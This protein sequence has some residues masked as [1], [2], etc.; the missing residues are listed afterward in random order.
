MSRTGFLYD[1]TF[2]EHNTGWKHPEKRQRLIALIEHLTRTGLLSR[3]VP[4]TPVS[5]TPDDIALV[6]DRA[7]IEELA[8][9]CAR[10]EIFEPD[11]ST[12]GSP[13][14]YKAA[15]LAAGAVQTAIDAV[16]A[17]A[18]TNAFCAVRPPGHHAERD[19]AG[20]FC[21]F[22]NA[23]IGARH[24]QRR[25]GINRVAIIDWDVHHGN[26]TQQ[27]FY[28]DP[29][30]LYISTHQYP[31]YPMTGRAH[32]TGEGPGT[33][34]TLNLPVAAGATDTDYQ[35]LFSGEIRTA[36][37]GFNPEFLLIS[38]GFDAHTADPLGGVM[39]STECFGDLTRL[40]CRWAD[41]FCQGR[42]VSILEGGYDV[43]ALSVS[44]AAHLSA[45]LGE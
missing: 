3:L 33:G 40:V 25:H 28:H 4:L 32:E 16:M 42:L 2:L 15:L 38:A 1:P 24:L 11:D 43:T 29:T 34:Y 20:G 22:C 13:G 17:G 26:G 44:V 30:V 8:A 39:L 7:Y 41:E 35:R 18:V 12:I 27:A 19:K 21:F 6:H 36:I 14:T 31:H 37:A 9:L 23:A 45:L 10:G 5:A